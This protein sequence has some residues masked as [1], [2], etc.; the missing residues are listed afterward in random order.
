MNTVRMSTTVVQGS[1]RWVDQALEWVRLIIGIML[2]VILPTALLGRFIS[3]ETLVQSSV[4]NTVLVQA[5]AILVSDLLLRQLTLF[6]GSRA[7]FY[8][9]PVFTACYIALFIFY[10]V[11]RFGY[12]RS[13]LFF[14]YFVLIGWYFLTY[15]VSKRIRRPRF[16]LV[17]GGNV[18]DLKSTREIEAVMINDPHEPLNDYDGVIADFRARL[19]GDWERLIAARAISGQPVYHSKQVLESITGQVSIEHLSEN[20]FGSLIPSLGYAAVKSLIDKISCILLL[21]V[22]IPLLLIVAALVRSSSPGPVLFRQTRI[23]FRGE[24]FSIYK[25]RTM[26]GCV[27]PA[28][29]E[30]VI[31]RSNDTRITPIGR[32]LRRSRLDELPQII[33][34]LRGEMSWIGPRPEAELLS[35]WYGSEL[36]FYPYRHIVRPGISGWA[37]V[38]QGH[39]A[40]LDEVLGK[41]RYDFFY[42]KYFSPSLDILIALRTARVLLMGIGWR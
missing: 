39:V 34:I 18:S 38:N 13:Q 1:T 40:A 12:S 16:A 32:F 25:F 28:C 17:P 14:G 31:T 35:K 15:F 6:P 3:G 20:N 4:Q 2:A 8:I 33:N 41:L 30:D 29:R 19:S 24:P 42:I 36:P 26:V 9:V 10:F 11:S 37:Q 22:L 5:M 21:P 23:G 27:G 7:S